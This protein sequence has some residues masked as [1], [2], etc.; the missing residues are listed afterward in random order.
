TADTREML[1]P[2]ELAVPAMRRVVSQ[3]GGCI[4]WGGTVH[5]SPADDVLIRIERPLDLDCVGQLVASVLS[6]KAA[7]GATDVLIDIPV[8]PTAKV[9][10][11]GAAKRLCSDFRAVGREVGLSVLP[12]LTDGT[13]PVGYGIGP[14]LE[15]RDVLA[16]LQ[17]DPDA[18]PDL[19]ERGLLLAGHILEMAKL[20]PTGGGQALAREILQDG[21]AWEKFQAIC[22][23]QGGMREPPTAPFARP[24][25]ATRSGRVARIDNRRLAR[26]AK[27]AGAPRDSSAGLVLHA[28]V[29]TLVEPGHPLLTLYAEAKGELEYAM[30][31][32]T[33]GSEII[34]LEENV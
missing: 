7:A 15:A 12:V 19:R 5:L 22:R 30:A 14:A 33:S 4:I 24:L 34:S 11:V 27:L 3:E 32:A 9:R 20:V 31:Y 6:K 18:P 29:G 16:V 13:Q 26:V 23:A 21:R 25:N 17:C 8:G 1:A 10:S 28:R 2:V